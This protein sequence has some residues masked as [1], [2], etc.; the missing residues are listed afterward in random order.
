MLTLKKGDKVIWKRDKSIWKVL[1]V[2]TEKHNNESMTYA[3]IRKKE[4]ILYFAFPEDLE[5][6][7]S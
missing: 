1:N 5:V 4:E 6:Y 2:K 7:N 3:K